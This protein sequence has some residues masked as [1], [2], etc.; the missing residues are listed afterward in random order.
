MIQSLQP[1]QIILSEAN[2]T[3]STNKVGGE[4]PRR[5]VDQGLA[6]SPNQQYSASVFIFGESPIRHLETTQP[7]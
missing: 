5:S 6:T 7:C 1:E 2:N 4:C 3:K